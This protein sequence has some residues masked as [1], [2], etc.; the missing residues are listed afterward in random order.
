MGCEKG[1]G[2]GQSVKLSA[3]GV[4]GGTSSDSCVHE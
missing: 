4:Q 2:S 3:E 1:H